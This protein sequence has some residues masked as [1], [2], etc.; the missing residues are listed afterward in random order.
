M[1]KSVSIN[2]SD[3]SFVKYVKYVK[4]YKTITATVSY[5]LAND[6][7]E[8]H[9]EYMECLRNDPFNTPWDN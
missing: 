3:Y 8:L 7:K 5:L 1:S 6:T 9:D 4:K 2:E